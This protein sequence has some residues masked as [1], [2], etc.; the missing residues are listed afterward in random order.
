MFS[1][2]PR[3]DS[4]RQSAGR[5][6][7]HPVPALERPR[8]RPAVGAWT[9]GGKTSDPARRNPPELVLKPNRGRLSLIADRIVIRFGTATR[10]PWGLNVRCAR[11]PS[12]PAALRPGGLAGFAGGLGWSVG[13]LRSDAAPPPPRAPKTRATRAFDQS[14]PTPFRTANR[15]TIGRDGASACPA[16]S[17]SGFYDGLA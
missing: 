17:L 12:P 5:H 1:P 7:G 8:G 11:Q 3:D 13:G 4:H 9:R 10:Q 16:R 14:Y 2:P 6:L 15:P